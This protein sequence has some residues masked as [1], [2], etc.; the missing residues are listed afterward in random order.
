MKTT[1]AGL[2]TL[3][4]L[5]TF[6][7]LAF[8]L[9]LAAAGSPEIGDDG[10]VTFRVGAGEAGE[11]AVA[12]Q[13]VEGGPVSLERGED[14]V[15]SATVGPVDPG[16]YEYRFIVDGMGIVDPGNPAIKP[17]RVPKSS[18][19]HVPGE[20]PL[21]WD[22]Q[23]VPH[24]TLHTH[25][26]FSKSL[27]QRRE[28]V[29][30]TPPGYEGGT[31]SLP[32]LILIHGFGDNQASWSAH[33][34][35]HWIL[36]NL[37][38]EGKAEPMVVVMPDGHP[39][40]PGTGPR[41]GYGEAN[42]AALEGEIMG[43]ILPLIR[44]KY[45]IREGSDSHAIAGLS[46]GGNHALHTGLRHLDT[47]AWISSFSGGLQLGSIVDALPDG[48][49]ANGKIEL[50]WIAIGKDDRR[51]IGRNE[52]LVAELESRGIEHTWLIT[53]GDHSWP[54]WRRYFADFAPLLFRGE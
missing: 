28:L 40:A 45:R 49:A 54:V 50:L 10:R 21:V 3:V 5:V 38:A 41:D 14:G 48:E 34:K 17:Q 35:A 33:G 22:W 23:D 24:G 47:F 4:A 31:D 2:V 16:V 29:V 37:I 32:L 36:D 30:Y 44:A 7:S 46:M 8:P 15:W 25:T 53:E 13:F 26:Y 27:G 42:A 52:E 51:L 1:A 9:V 20:P 39:V 18:I 11:V 12:G 19:L 43:D 6:I